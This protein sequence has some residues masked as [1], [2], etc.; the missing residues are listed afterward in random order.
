M[1]SGGMI[2][3]DE[4]ECMVDVAKFYLGFTGVES[5]GKCAPCRI[6]GKSMLALMESSPTARER[7]RCGGDQ[8]ELGTQCSVARCARWVRP[9][10]TGVAHEELP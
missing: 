9:A 4:D 10:P 3:M 8:D 6:G 5:C 7:G 2:V 1:G